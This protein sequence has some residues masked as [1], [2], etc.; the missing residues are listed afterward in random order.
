MVDHYNNF[1]VFMAEAVKNTKERV[2]DQSLNAKVLIII[3]D[4]LDGVG[5]GGF[6]LV[7]GILGLG[8]VAFSLALGTF[9]ISPVGLVIVAMGGGIVMWT[10]WRNKKLPLAVKKIGDRYKPEWEKAYGDEAQV[11]KL[12]K[13]V[14]DALF[15]ELTQG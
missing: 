9:F 4:I 5:W 6:T 13:E 14:E 12:L 10:L 7:C 2:L 1:A 11:D 8:I 15:R 3:H